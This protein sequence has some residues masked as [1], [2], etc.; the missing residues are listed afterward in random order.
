VKLFFRV[1]KVLKNAVITVKSSDRVIISKKKR[2]VVPGEM[3]TAL[4]MS[5]KI[6]ALTG[7]IEVLVEGEN[8]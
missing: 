2:I 4:L 3:E 7:D 8:D 1:N 5:D 6:K